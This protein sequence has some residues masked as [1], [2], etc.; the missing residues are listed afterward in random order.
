MTE[1]GV[2]MQ[3]DG[4]LTMADRVAPV[5]FLIFWSSGFVAAKVGL[6]GAE[7]LTFLALRF[8]IVSAL[9]VPAALLLGSRLPRDPRL[10]L[11]VAMAGLIMQA[12]YFGSSYMA[13]DAGGSAGGVALVLGM[14]P[15]VTACIVGPFL[16]ERVSRRQWIGLALGFAGVIL[17]LAEKLSAGVGTPAGIVWSCAALVAITFGTLYQKRFCPSFDLLAGGAI[18][19]TFAALAVGILAFMF[20]DMTVRWS[21]P[22]AW[23]LAYLVLVN[24]IVAIGLLSFMIRRGAASR[25][26][27]LF[28]LVPPGAALVAWL[29]VDETLTPAGLLGMAIAAIGVML[30]MRRAAAGVR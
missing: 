6:E 7:P 21:Q 13:F 1:A 16:G 22:F 24:S 2:A 12:L 8:A 26:T 10:I 29:V 9:L 17:V 23:S 18:Q 19:F 25:V 30:V 14:Q 15:I 4:S 5:L 28:F 27:A 3:R 20:E 11:H